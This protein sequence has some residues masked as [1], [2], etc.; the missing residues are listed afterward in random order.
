MKQ[1]TKTKP[2]SR[3]KG[4]KPTAT[5]TIAFVLDR[6]G[7]MS[8]CR[9]DTIGG[10]NEYIKAIKEGKA[11]DKSKFTMV[12][13]DSGGI[14]TLYD[15]AKVKDV[16]PLTNETYVPRAQTP[17]YDAIGKTIHRMLEAKAKDVLFTI[18]TDGQENDSREYGFKALKDLMKEC[19]E[20]HGWNFSFVGMGM[21]SWT[22][23]EQLAVGTRSASNFIKISKDPASIKRSF[24]R[25]GGQSVTYACAITSD[26]AAEVTEMKANFWNKKDTKD[27][28]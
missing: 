22:A 2:K 11:S 8:S 24:A 15:N 19:E 23:V 4:K 7:S 25:A 1:K 18:L 21:D 12:Q 28:E 26:N 20:K 9:D 14:D 10:F 16:K 27:N 5:L 6:S 17:L 13:F 3:I